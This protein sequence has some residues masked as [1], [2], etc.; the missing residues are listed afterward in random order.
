MLSPVSGESPDLAR[1][2]SAPNGLLSTR[3]VHTLKLDL[4]Q[5]DVES[6][7]IWLTPEATSQHDHCRSPEL[8]ICFGG[9]QAL[10]LL[11][12]GAAYSCVESKWLH[13]NASGIRILSTLP[14][15][16]AHVIGAVGGQTT[17]IKQQVLVNVTIPGASFLLNFLVVPKLVR[18]VIIGMHSLLRMKAEIKTH[19]GTL[20]VYTQDDKQ[21]TLTYCPDA[22]R[23]PTSETPSILISVIDVNA[24]NLPA[25]LKSELSEGQLIKLRDI[26]EKYENVFSDQPGRVKNFLFSLRVSPSIQNF[27]MRHYPV[28]LHF[29][30]QVGRE[31]E[32][33]LQLGIIEKGPSPFINPLRIVK[34]S[35]GSLRLC[36]DARNLNQYLLSEGEAPPGLDEVFSIFRGAA[37]FSSFDLT[38]SFWQVTLEPSSRPYTAFLFDNTT[39]Q[40]VVVPFG[41][42]TSTSALL[43][44]LSHIFNLESRTFCLRFVDEC[45]VLSPD[46]DSHL[47]HLEYILGTFSR[48]GLTLKLGKTQWF[49]PEIKFLGMIIHS[50]GIRPDCE[51][52]QAIQN[53]HRPT[54][55][56]ELRGYLGFINFYRRFQP[57]LAR[58]TLPLTG[59]LRKGT[60]WQWT[61]EIERAFQESKET[62]AQHVLLCFPE[63][64]EPFYISADASGHCVGAHLYQIREDG[65]H[66]IAFTSQSLDC[67]QQLYSVSELELLAI[68][69][70]LKKFRNYVIGAKVIVRTDHRALEHLQN[71]H[72][73]SPRL[74]RLMLSLQEYD[75]EI[76]YVP[77]SE[78]LIAD[79]L[80]RYCSTHGSPPTS[81]GVLI[82]SINLPHSLQTFCGD[83]AQFQKRDPRLRGIFER[84]KKHHGL[85]NNNLLHNGVLYQRVNDG[86][87]ILL[88]SQII[89]ELTRFIHESYSHIGV[90]KCLTIIREAFHD[91]CLK[92]R[93]RLD[94]R[95]C[96]VCQQTKTSHAMHAKMLTVSAAHPRDLVAVDFYGPLPSSP[97]NFRY[98]LV[99]LDIATKF[100]RLYPL[101]KAS[102]SAVLDCMVHDYIPNY[103]NVKAILSDNGTQFTSAL[104][105]SKMRQLNIK[106]IRTSIRHP[107]ANP[108]ERYMGTLAQYLRASLYREPHT[109]WC[110]KLRSVEVSMN[111]TAHSTTLTVPASLFLGRPSLRAWSEHVPE[112]P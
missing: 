50:H 82:A 79:C 61:S 104:W 81:H 65:H 17:R 99:M 37:L 102:G 64:G 35:D 90:R 75:L 70:A 95:S 80:S 85:T 49:Q 94:I 84:T 86:W 93:V 107:A 14:I 66:P 101:L 57:N 96:L 23:R 87:R 6:P 15:R 42:K 72:P 40:F 58:V 103:G 48:S 109:R 45:L 92:K 68:A 8:P 53:Y 69:T 56:R 52:I 44:A 29:K 106:S 88:P 46:V 24:L 74:S 51:R 31:I 78:N 7:T 63:P 32:R 30:E 36:L 10:A 89:S 110:T 1:M 19:E 22:V 100:V 28:P 76:Q 41:L 21:I 13:Q 108:A 20:S 71:S 62:F 5:G 38:N 26:L 12:T 83:I 54:N 98:I 97:E 73:S 3:G 105:K 34:K 60:K 33:M 16:K 18:P 39:Y 43:R 47:H 9:Y 67:H 55:I 59:L 77:G 25:Q 91:R 27:K 112:S 2:E 11:D 4:A 111:E